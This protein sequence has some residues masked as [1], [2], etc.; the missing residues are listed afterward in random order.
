LST[1]VSEKN[2]LDG[3]VPVIRKLIIFNSLHFW[4]DV[5]KQLQKATG[6]DIIHC[7]QIAIIAHTKGSAVVKS[8]DFEELSKVDN[9]LKEISLVTKIK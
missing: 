4:T 2:I 7:E 5:V 8:G 6:Y 3:D 9:V 1:K